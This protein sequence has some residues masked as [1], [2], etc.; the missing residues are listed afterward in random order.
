MKQIYLLSF[1]CAFKSL[2]VSFFSH[3]IEYLNDLQICKSNHD[4]NYIYLKSINN[5]LDNIYNF[6]YLD[7]IDMAPNRKNDEINIIERTLLFKKCMISIRQKIDKYIKLYNINKII[8]CIEYQP[9]MNDKS[10]II[11]HQLLYEFSNDDLFDVNIIFPHIKN[12]I[13]FSKSLHYNTFLEKYNSVY[14]VNKIH[15]TTNF[16]Y[17]LKI[18]NKEH[19]I[20]HIKKKNLDDISDS[21]FQ[22]LAY[23]QFIYNK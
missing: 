19:L 5:I 14:K 13:H 17:L 21:V 2:G 8:I 18:T 11:L 10:K 20:Q 6:Y 7:V 1:D 23:I 22:A 3:N 4:K 16:L 15:T 12:K 9:S